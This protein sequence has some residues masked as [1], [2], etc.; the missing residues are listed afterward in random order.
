MFYEGTFGL[1]GAVGNMNAE[2][3]KAMLEEKLL[4]AAK[5][6]GDISNLPHDDAFVHLA[7]YT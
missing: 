1:E 4:S 5:V 3:Y 7:A 6:L 2:Y